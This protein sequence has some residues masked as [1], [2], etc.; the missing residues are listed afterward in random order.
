[1]F[2][3]V[4]LNIPALQLSFAS[5]SFAFTNK[6]TQNGRS[7]KERT[8]DQSSIRGQCQSCIEKKVGITLLSFYLL[9]N[10]ASSLCSLSLSLSLSTKETRRCRILSGT[11][12]SSHVP[13]RMHALWGRGRRVNRHTQRWIR[14]DG[15]TGGIARG[16][17]RGLSLPRRTR[18]GE[19]VG[20]RVERVPAGR[21]DEGGRGRQK[22]Q[23]GFLE[24][25]GVNV[26]RGRELAGERGGEKGEG[27]VAA[28]FSPCA[29]SCCT[30]VRAY[31]L[32]RARARAQTHAYV[33]ENEP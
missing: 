1:M 11:C 21:E 16:R 7:N 29:R 2:S 8:N 6:Q 3:T 33:R 23:Y 27:K 20:S 14:E 13:G 17:A 12:V 9:I 30:C 15:G 31:S 19:G 10:V 18:D 24:F 28:R 25:V 32:A 22:E 26:Q 4:V 5:V